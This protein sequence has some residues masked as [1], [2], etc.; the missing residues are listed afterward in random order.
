[1]K[2]LNLESSQFFKEILKEVESGSTLLTASSKTAR[3]FIFLY[4]VSKIKNDEKVWESPKIFTLKFYADLLF[5]ELITEKMIP[6]Y[7]DSLLLMAKTIEKNYPEGTPLIDTAVEYLRHYE[8]KEKNKID[9]ISYENEF[10]TLRNKV[11]SE[12]DE[13]KKQNNF[14]SISEEFTEI[15]NAV[16]GGIIHFPEKL[17]VLDRNDFSPLES[18]FL[19]FIA[20]KSTICDYR[21]DFSK[22]TLN[23]TISLYEDVQSEVEAVL[24]KAINLWENGERSIGIAYFDDYYKEKIENIL[25]DFPN[26]DKD[27]QRYFI[28]DSSKVVHFVSYEIIKNILTISKGVV[29]ENLFYLVSSPLF[30]RKLSKAELKSLIDNIK[31]NPSSA[32]EKLKKEFSGDSDLDIFLSDRKEKVFKIASALKNI[33]EKKFCFVE[34]TSLFLS[35]NEILK[36]LEFFDDKYWETTPTEFEKFLSESLRPVSFQKQNEFSGIQ[37]ISYRNCI[38]QDFK[39]L[40]LV[41]ANSSVIPAPIPL[42]PFFSGEEKEKCDVLK[43]ENHFKKEEEFLKRVFASNGDVFISRAKQNNDNPF[44]ASPLLSNRESERNWNKYNFEI[45]RFYIPNYLSSVVKTSFTSEFKKGERIKSIAIPNELYVTKEATNIFSCPFLF[46]VKN[47]LMLEEPEEIHFFMEIADVGSFLHK[48]IAKI[49]EKLK[50][51]KTIENQQE[52]EIKTLVRSFIENENLPEIQKNSLFFFLFGQNSRKGF[53]DEFLEFEKN[54]IVEGWEIYKIEDSLSSCISELDDKEITGRPDRI[55]KNSQNGK[56]RIIDF[57]AKSS[58]ISEKDKFQ[59]VIYEKLLNLTEGIKDI[60]AGIFKLFSENNKFG[61]YKDDTKIKIY[62]R[63]E[64]SYKNIKEGSICPAPYPHPQKNGSPCDYCLFDL[65]CHIDK[66]T[67]SEV[68]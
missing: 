15:K 1:M 10:Y 57:K 58:N 35:Y 41:G 39:K 42:Y 49:G 14:V 26:G 37:V 23:T 47:F 22:V 33:L 21:I 11:F 54:R 25:L 32:I 7:E 28:E 59:L 60:E 45:N 46:F 56:V 6:S 44:L 5:D 27:S 9:L 64:N 19:D 52:D 13:L 62:E 17:V 53:L 66:K 8:F 4:R 55:E 43:L 12:F 38:Y 51:L 30:K 16:N 29:V 68:S 31:T 3:K 50:E 63:F 40:F 24:N 67:E 34:N 18:D 48:I 20:Q 2:Y 61:S 65:L 36:S